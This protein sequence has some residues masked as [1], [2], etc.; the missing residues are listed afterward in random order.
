MGSPAGEVWVFVETLA[1]AAAG[2]DATSGAA[3]S[4]ASTM[5]A[6][7]RDAHTAGGGRTVRTRDGGARAAGPRAAEVSLELL[8]QARVLAD[9]LG[10]RTGAVCAGGEPAR[11]LAPA[12]VAA[13]ADTVYLAVDDSLI[14]Y[15]AQP[16]ARVVT[17][18]VRH[19]QPQIVLYGATTTGRDLAPRVASA[20]RAGLTAD[21]TDL[22]IGD[23]EVKG[24][25]TATCSTRSG[26]PS[27]AT[28]SPPSSTPTTGR[29]WPPCARASCACPT[30]L[31]PPRRRRRAERRAR[32]SGLPGGHNGR[33]TSAGGP[34]LLD[35]LDFAVNLVQP[36]ARG[37]VG[38]PQGRP[39]DRRRRRGVGSAAGFKLL[40][41]WPPRSAASW[42]PA[43][44]RR[45]R[46][47]RQGAPGRPDRHHGAPRALHRRRHLGRGA[48][49]RRHGPVGQDHR[50]QHGSAGADLLGRPL[51]H[52]RRPSQRG[53]HADQGLPGEGDDEPAPQPT[54]RRPRRGREQLLH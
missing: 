21:C 4:G 15:L 1:G 16:Y 3:S 12:L 47:D 30:R 45:R 18:A 48:A 53:A 35:D 14:E 40:A 43:R 25:A 37:E 36:I 11:A 20:L 17:E 26:R 31:E 32:S 29:R 6:A 34:I 49:P 13:G 8:G 38:R 51:R 50:H 42:A 23:H 52:R 39:G 33:P 2:G 7:A 44:R 54:R 10:T 27:A 28:S 5:S 22:A 24:V 46:L 19:F 41:T 9:R